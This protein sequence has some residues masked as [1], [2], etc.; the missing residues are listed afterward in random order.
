MDVLLDTNAIK[1]V[2]L[3]GA[4][5]KALASYLHKTRSSLLLP[6][7]VVQELRAQRRNEL[8]Q[9]MRELQSA[10]KSIRRLFPNTRIES[11]ALD[12]DGALRDYQARLLSITDD[13][14]VIENESEDLPEL[15][16][17]LANRVR[18]ATAKG[19]EARDVLIWLCV[20]RISTTS[21]LAFVSGDLKAFFDG[22][23][24]HPDLL[25]DLG[26]GAA[27]VRA[28]RK[29]DDLLQELHGRTSFVTLSWLN[30]KVGQRVVEEAVD[31]FLAGNDGLIESYIGDQGEPTGYTSLLQLVQH[32]VR[33]FVVSD[34]EGDEFY[35]GAT[36]W[37]ELEIETEYYPT[38]R[39]EAPF[40]SWDLDTG[41]ETSGWYGARS[42]LVKC[43]YPSVEFTVQLDIQAEEI[44]RATVQALESA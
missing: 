37:A 26:S 3:D 25:A 28:Y 15:V 30:E 29:L 20:R 32:D 23:G 5:M 12:L 8:S 35:V 6:Q 10:H 1:A 18:P 43:I 17:R 36:V 33:S 42:A 7:V 21:P 41:P 9:A 11:P 27:N 39:F 44:V 34:I 2:G 22:G 19:E 14:R 16:R 24:L 4:A 40:R 38:H 13:V 31:R